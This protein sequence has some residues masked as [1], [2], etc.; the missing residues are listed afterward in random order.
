MVFFT[1]NDIIVYSKRF[2][3]T[4]RQ[5]SEEFRGWK[6]NVPPLYSPSNKT[7]SLADLTSIDCQT[8]RYIYLKSKIKEEPSKEALRGLLIHKIITDAVETVKKLIY[9]GVKEPNEFRERMID[10]YYIELR[11]L[12]QFKE[13]TNYPEILKTIWDYATNIYSS[14][15]VKAKTRSQFLSRDSLVSLI[16]PFNVEFPVDG[17]TVGLSQNLRIDELIPQI[18]LII[19]IKAGKIKS[20]YEIAL[21]GYAIAYESNFETP[22]DFGLLCSVR[23]DN[24]FSYKCEHRIISDTLRQEFIEIR[25]KALEVLEQLIEPQLPKVCDKDC[26]FLKHCGV[27][28]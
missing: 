12:E 28:K 15:L 14:E 22:V 23:V 5:I 21:A 19:E 16:V 1:Y 13:I 25:D 24:E 7:I 17:S 4:P 27:I 8:F 6:W 3:E 20:L 26:P 2:R 10:E 18:P 11:V 9:E